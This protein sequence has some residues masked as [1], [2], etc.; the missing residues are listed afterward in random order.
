MPRIALRSRWGASAGAP[1]VRIDARFG[2]ATYTVELHRIDDDGEQVFSHKGL[3][4]GGDPL[5]LD[6]LRWKGDHAGLAIGV[7]KDHDGHPDGAADVSDE[8]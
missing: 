2:K 6:Y 8:D 3:S 7:D 1:T 4:I 5:T